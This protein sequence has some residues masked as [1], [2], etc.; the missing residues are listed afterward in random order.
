MNS[1]DGYHGYHRPEHWDRVHAV[2]GADGSAGNAVHSSAAEA[3][4]ELLDPGQRVVDLC[5]GSNSLLPMLP[6]GLN[7]TGA[8]FSLTAL[9]TARRRAGA[10]SCEW[11]QADAALLPFGSG[12][13]DAACCLSTLWTLADPKQALAEL[14]R[15]IRPGGTLLIHI[16][17]PPSTCRL[18]T[19]GAVSIARAIPQ[20]QR[21]EGITGP[22]DSSA[23]HVTSMLCGAG[24]ASPAWKA[25]AFER[26]VDGIEVYWSEFATLAPT[27]YSAYREADAGTRAAADKLLAGLLRQSQERSGS[28]V[29][30]LTWQFALAQR[31]ADQSG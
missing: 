31:Q 5:C 25:A 4:G 27:S 15:V 1:A 30:G 18:I 9:K 16:W 6:P 13:V 24:F 3:L 20:M 12:T 23:E 7:R 10:D 29:L 17:G 21:P 14:A 22:F 8:D 26:P 28:D 2:S 19:L 11:L